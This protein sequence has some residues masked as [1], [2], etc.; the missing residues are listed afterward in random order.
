[1]ES[2]CLLKKKLEVEGGGWRSNRKS[3]IFF[4]ES[5]NITP[6]AQSYSQP[7]IFYKRYSLPKVLLTPHCD[8][9]MFLL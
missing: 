7:K 3:G 9:D 1:M 4:H 5:D 6:L 2:N 8:I